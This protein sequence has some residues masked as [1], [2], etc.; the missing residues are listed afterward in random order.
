MTRNEAHQGI[1]ISVLKCTEAYMG[2]LKG[3]NVSLEQTCGRCYVGKR[4]VDV[5]SERRVDG[6]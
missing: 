4:V 5:T 3:R 2:A 1:L 6:V